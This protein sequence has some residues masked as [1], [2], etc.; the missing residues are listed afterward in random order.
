MYLCFLMFFFCVFDLSQRLEYSG[1]HSQFIH[2]KVKSVRNHFT[3]MLLGTS[4]GKS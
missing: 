1:R 3:D 2:C 4:H